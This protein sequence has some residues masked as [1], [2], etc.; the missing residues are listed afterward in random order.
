[1]NRLDDDTAG[2]FRDE[3]RDAGFGVVGAVD[4]AGDHGAEG[5]LVFGVRRRGQAAHCS[6]VEGIVEADDFVLGP[7]RLPYLAHFPGELYGGF[8][9]FGAGVAD[10]YFGRFGH[11]P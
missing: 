3:F 4:E 5:F 9:G 7:G 10:E 1:M 11:G 8:V 2:F 6:P